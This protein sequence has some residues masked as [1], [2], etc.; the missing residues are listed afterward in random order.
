MT[1]MPIRDD[2]DDEDIYIKDDVMNYD[3]NSYD[4]IIAIEDN[5]DDEYD[6]YKEI[7]EYFNMDLFLCMRRI[8]LAGPSTFKVLKHGSGIKLS[9]LPNKC[10]QYLRTKRSRSGNKKAWGKRENWQNF[11][12]LTEERSLFLRLYLC[13]NRAMYLQ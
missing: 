10:H 1:I 9:S 12:F 2:D 6:N 3:I 5:C 11:L 8:I 4:V 7:S 13:M